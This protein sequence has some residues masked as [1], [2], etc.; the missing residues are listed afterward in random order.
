M[1]LSDDQTTATLIVHADPD[2]S[3]TARDFTYDMEVG[4]DTTPWEVTEGIRTG[5]ISGQSGI[6][7]ILSELLGSGESRNQTIALD[8]GTNVFVVSI[9]AT[10]TPG[11][12]WGDGSG[13][14]PA[15]ATNAD[16]IEK[17]NHLSWVLN[18]TPIDS[19]PED[20]AGEVTGSF[21]PATLEYGMRH[22]DGPLDPLDVI[23][24]SP[25]LTMSSTTPSAITVS[26]ECV[27]AADLGTTFDA[28][29]NTK[30][31]T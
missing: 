15:D 27:L 6:H 11:G 12:T 20:L 13:S 23:V 1:T 17:Q 14:L 31:G 19:L 30:R 3:G 5:T 25:R 22:P 10:T 9:E 4:G 26:M 2:D 28:Q 21:G 8:L 7:T 16:P 24:E 18:Q 29:G